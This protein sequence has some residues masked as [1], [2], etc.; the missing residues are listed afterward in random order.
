MIISGGSAMQRTVTSVVFRGRNQVDCESNAV[1]LQTGGG[2]VL[3]QSRYSCISAGTEIA[4]L[5]GLEPF[6]FPATLGNR[7]IGRVISAGR[8]G[9]DLKEGDLVFSYT[10]HRSHNLT[11]KLVA[12]LPCAL[13]LP[14]TPLLGMAMVALAGVQTA[15]PELGDVA[16]VTGGG[17]VGQF[18]AQL[19]KLSGAE[20]IMVDP[21]AGRLRTARACGIEHTIQGAADTARGEILDRTRGQGARLLLECTGV[22]S[23]CL[24]AASLL[25]RSAT[26]VLAGSPRGTL[27]ADLTPLLQAVHL[28]RDQG[29]LT[30]KGAHEWKVPLH[31][32]P[33][34]RHSQRENL[35]LL[36]ALMQSGSLKVKPLL[37]AV[38]LPQDAARAY[39]DLQERQNDLLGSVFDWTGLPDN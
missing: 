4:K 22:P 37:S 7:A 39:A 3:V 15:K 5:T 23:V 35:Q 12:K 16:V 32:S 30:L 8:Q 26:M 24:T 33:Y 36:A 31:P 29:D 9:G 13:D 25:R 34:S 19:L 1:D 21:A 17:L 38:Y 6:A 11:D 20:V 2:G 14:E 18:A 10:P 28:W 27:E